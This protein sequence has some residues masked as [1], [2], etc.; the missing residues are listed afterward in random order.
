MRSV[1]LVVAKD[2]RIL[3]RS[4]LLLG[5][6]VAYPILIALLVGLVAGYANAK[7]RVALVDEEG[8]PAV[9]VVG[10]ER[11][12]VAGTIE[13]VDDDVTL[14][15]LPGDEAGRQL[16]SGKIVASLTVPEGF[17]A[18][19]RGMVRS[20]RLVLRTTQGGISTRVVQQVEA[21]VYALNRQ[22]QR[23]YIDA[24]VGYIRLIQ[25]GGSGTF[26]GRRFDV[27]GLDGTARALEELPPDER[28][29]EIRE[30]VRVAGLAL[31]QTDDALRA[32]ANPIELV[33]GADR[34]RTWVLSAQ[35]QAYAL[36]LTITFLTL[37]LAAAA[38]ASERDENA[39]G[40][41]GRG[42]VTLGELVAAKV[43]LAAA[44]ALA[45]GLAIVLSFG[46]IIE[47]GGVE[48][49]EPWGRVPLV[50]AG[51]ALA[52]A[53]L[54]ALGALL[55]ALVR[56][57]RA[58]SLVALLVVLPIVFLGLVPR[59]VVP[60]AGWVSNAFPFVHAVRLFASALYDASPWSVLAR[61]AA[62]LA[63]LGAVF[64]LL[65]RLGARRL[66]V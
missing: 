51:L 25:R 30:F 4:P 55:G 48:G 41:L 43:V 13:R 56:E 49:G 3:R 35:I 31:D 39:I 47:L 16:R 64:A 14:V 60:V 53:S 42:L 28:V 63:G 59:E 11:F 32:T 44:L 58:A 54:G 36:A 66:L 57:A 40:R 1:A 29:D 18:D 19:L 50:V 33:R 24:N 61:E 46:L 65:A 37:L 2:L 52:G 6:L 45:L 9:V 21:L 27:L 62:W 10:G 7:P 34:G 15:R 8:L 20:P 26:L 17:L 23:A 5:V 12:D 22:L 38:L